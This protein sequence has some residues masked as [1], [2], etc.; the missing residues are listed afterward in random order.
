MFIFT[1]LEWYLNIIGIPIN[2]K[3]IRIEAKY[4]F[5]SD[6]H[7]IRRCYDIVYLI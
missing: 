5:M 6:T 4:S 2:T 1:L 7:K 3:I